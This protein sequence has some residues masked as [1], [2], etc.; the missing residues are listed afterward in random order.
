MPTQ[1]M[2]P[3]E[4]DR[5]G[6]KRAWLSESKEAHGVGLP[7]P[8]HFRLHRALGFGSRSG[9]EVLGSSVMEL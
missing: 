2:S 8:A 3:E 4:V 1:R 5:Q 6:G 9:G 7:P